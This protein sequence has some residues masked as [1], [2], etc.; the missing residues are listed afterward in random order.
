[1]EVKQL[2]N[3]REHYFPGK[4]IAESRQLMSNH[5]NEYGLT[6]RSIRAWEDNQRSIQQWFVK[7]ANDFDKDNIL[8]E[9]SCE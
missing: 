7:A 4:T 5:F 2:K 1:M 3:F 6:E 8:K 9:Y